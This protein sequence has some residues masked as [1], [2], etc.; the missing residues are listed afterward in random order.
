MVKPTGRA[1]MLPYLRLQKE[2]DLMQDGL[3]EARVLGDRRTHRPASSGVHTRGQFLQRTAA[4]GGALGGAALLVAALPRQA[5]SA[6][7]AKQD[8]RILSFALRLEYLQAA[9]Y[10][11]AAAGGS[12]QGE[13]LEFAEVVGR[14][15]RAHITFLRKRLGKAA[16]NEPTFDFGDSTRDAKT[17]AANAHLLEETATAAYVGQGAN[18][19]TPLLAP[20][21][22]MTSVE[23]R[24]A[25]WIS[26]L[27]GKNPAPHAADPSMTGSQV[28]RALRKAGLVPAQ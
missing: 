12:I 23:A 11:A 14:H 10:E 9:F 15:E 28:S 8:R 21:G 17:F 1:A 4:G 16:A 19:T 20:F 18:L 27:T 22:E 26:D 25:A 13:L 24:Q 2:G 7:S 6:P 3:D 5:A